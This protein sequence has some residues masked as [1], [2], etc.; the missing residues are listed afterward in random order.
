MQSVP[1]HQLCPR[2]FR[3]QRQQRHIRRKQALCG[4]LG[5][6]PGQPDERR[7]RGGAW[8]SSDQRGAAGASPGDRLG[9]EPRGQNV[10]SPVPPPP[11]S[12]QG[13]SHMTPKGFP[14]LEI[15]R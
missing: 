14:A 6:A 8:G 11:Q 5:P 2:R 9:M 7:P 3:L 13:G 10:H 4:G 1:R 12:S 15:L